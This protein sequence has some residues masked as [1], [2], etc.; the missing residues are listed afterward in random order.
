MFDKETL[1]AL[2]EAQAIHQANNAVAT[3]CD[4]KETV[5]LPSDYKLHD[6]EQ[7][8]PNR[9]RMRGVMETESLASFVAYVSVNEEPG[10]AVF[11]DQNAMTATAVLNLGQPDEPGHA[12][13]IAMLK[14][15]KTAAYRALLAHAN[16]NGYAQKA[17]AEFMEDWADNLACFGVDG[18]PIRVPQAVAAVRKITIDAMRKIESEEQSL[19]ASKSAFESVQAS[20]KEPLPTL[21]L[22]TCQPYADLDNRQFA[23]RLGVLTGESTPKVNLRISKLEEHQEAMA[24]ELASKI[25]DEFGE[26]TP[27]N[28]VMLGSYTRRT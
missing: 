4:T 6:L 15:V 16:G 5:A 7:Y 22:F 8:L 9:R 18:S 24:N 27:P 21:I 28:K 2:Q 12:D 17:I 10:T 19:G 3:S 14:P 1:A 20:S 23:L 25:I 26:D 13:N 11:V